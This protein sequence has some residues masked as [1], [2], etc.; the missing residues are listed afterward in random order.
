MGKRPQKKQRRSMGM[1]DEEKPSGRG[2]E[3][4]EG[5]GHRRSWGSPTGQE[6]RPR[7]CAWRGGGCCSRGEGCVDSK[8]WIPG[9]MDSNSAL[10]S[11]G[12][13]HLAQEDFPLLSGGH[14][15]GFSCVT[16]WGERVNEG[17]PVQGSA[18]HLVHR[19]H[20]PSR[21]VVPRC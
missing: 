8:C 14:S 17:L 16:W 7:G 3:G 1:R 2:P 13:S 21:A 4:Q 15:D 11:L 12:A 9:E 18:Q 5:C 10:T 6:Q 19:P 20:S